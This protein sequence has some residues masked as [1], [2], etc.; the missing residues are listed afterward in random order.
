[1]HRGCETIFL[2]FKNINIDSLKSFIE[3]WYVDSE[4]IQ[5]DPNKKNFYEKLHLLTSE[6][7][8][9]AVVTGHTIYG[10]SFDEISNIRLFKDRT[11]LLFLNPLIAM[12]R[13]EINEK[14][15]E[16]EISL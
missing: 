1:M 16:M 12:E 7:E 5:V 9:D 15:N 11:K 8:C 3:N 6:K 10:N 14:C 13:D 2:V 4:I